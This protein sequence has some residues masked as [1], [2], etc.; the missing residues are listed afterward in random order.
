M[1]L[2]HRII[3][4]ILYTHI[5]DDNASLRMSTPR[6]PARHLLNM[7]LCEENVKELWRDKKN[8]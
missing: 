8:T 4:I 2:S 5:I 6:A 1:R 3:N 7:K